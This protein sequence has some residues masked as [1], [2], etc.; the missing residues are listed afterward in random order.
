MDIYANVQPNDGPINE[1][2]AN[3]IMLDLEENNLSFQNFYFAVDELKKGKTLFY[4]CYPIC[5]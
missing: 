1:A 2:S 3:Q 5:P 4:K